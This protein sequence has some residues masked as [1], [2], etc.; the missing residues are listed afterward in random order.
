MQWAVPSLPSRA[1]VCISG[2]YLDA[3]REPGLAAPSLLRASDARGRCFLRNT[4]GIESRRCDLKMCISKQT[5]DSV[6]FAFVKPKKN[7]RSVGRGLKQLYYFVAFH[8]DRTVGVEPSCLGGL[9]G[10]RWDQ[11]GFQDFCWGVHQG[12]MIDRPSMAGDQLPSLST[13]TVASDAITHL[14]RRIPRGNRIA[15]EE[16]EM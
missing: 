15:M 10:G 3:T 5:A 4:V 6:C 1:G 9:V 12:N 16:G 8:V 7:T 13:R 2:I 11:F 14:N